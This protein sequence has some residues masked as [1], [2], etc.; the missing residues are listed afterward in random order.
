[1]AAQDG[2]LL[3]TVESDSDAGNQFTPIRRGIFSPLRDSAE[4]EFTLRISSLETNETDDLANIVVGVV[5]S[6]PIDPFQGVFLI[7]QA[8][9]PRPIIYLKTK[10]RGTSIDYL[11]QQYTLGTSHRVTIITSPV[12]ASIYANGDLLIGPSQIPT[13]PALYI[14]Y[15]LPR[16]G[17]INAV[18]SDLSLK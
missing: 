12:S 18:I 11:P 14:G 5:A 9:D 10:E 15:L 8:E 4:L 16:Q 13:F 7:Y 2:D 1:M 3:I 6:N 17:R